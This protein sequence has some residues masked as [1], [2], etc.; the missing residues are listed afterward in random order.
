MISAEVFT[1]IWLK[2]VSSESIRG[3]EALAAPPLI[4]AA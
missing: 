4:L 2:G 1:V 3:L